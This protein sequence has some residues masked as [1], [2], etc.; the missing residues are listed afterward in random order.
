MHAIDAPYYL[1]NLMKVNCTTHP[2]PTN[3]KFEQKKKLRLTKYFPKKTVKRKASGM[4]ITKSII[5]LQKDD[6]M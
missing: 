2:S 4:G 5:R 3:H 6:R 1:N